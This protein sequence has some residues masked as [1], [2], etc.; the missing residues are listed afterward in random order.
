MAEKY[1]LIRE[2]LGPHFSNAFIIGVTRSP[3]AMSSWFR[4]RF[5]DIEVEVPLPNLGARAAILAG[6]IRS[7]VEKFGGGVVVA[8]ADVGVDERNSMLHIVR[9]WSDRCHGFM[10]ADIGQLW[11]KAVE[12]AARHSS[13]S[14]LD[15]TTADLDNGLEA[16]RLSASLLRT[17][18]SGGGEFLNASAADE[19]ATTWEDIGGLEDVKK[20]LRS[21]IDLLLKTSAYL[22]GNKGSGG[23]VKQFRRRK[24]LRLSAGIL[25]YGPPGIS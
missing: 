5:F 10:P 11:S 4:S 6:C 22:A 19:N 16:A 14:R 9:P 21:E 7:T 17:A 1:G 12:H 18:L 24:T 25:L 3:A 8:G 13:L 20:Q 23:P 15:V 2:L